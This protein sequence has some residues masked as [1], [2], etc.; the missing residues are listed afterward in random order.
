VTKYFIYI[1]IYITEQALSK[2]KG[3]GYKIAILG[4][5]FFNFCEM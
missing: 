1:Y 5:C 4:L 3:D 2:W